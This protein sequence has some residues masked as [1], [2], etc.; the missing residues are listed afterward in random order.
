MTDVNVY[1]Y[2]GWLETINLAESL[3]WDGS[4]AWDEDPDEAE[5]AALVHIEEA[6][7]HIVFPQQKDNA[8]KAHNPRIVC[9]DGFSISVQA[10]AHSYCTPRCDYPDTPHTHVECGF[11]SSTPLTDDL[12]RQPHLL[13]LAYAED[14]YGCSDES[15][16]DFTETV[17][18]YVP[19]EI[20]KAELQQHGG[21]VQG[22]MPS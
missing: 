11:P 14:F 16:C 6:G 15:E 10:H 1:I 19:V 3:G 2:D 7:M 12:K 9:A 17:Y 4:E 13:P 18:G 5:N 21:I 22:E 8:M 20:V